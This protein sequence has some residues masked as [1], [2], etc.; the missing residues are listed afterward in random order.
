[1]S[2]YS[3]KLIYDYVKGN[4]IDN[5][6]I[7]ELESDYIF[8]KEVT[9]AS[10]DK[11]MYNLCDDKLK[12]NFEL[13]KFFIMK[14]KNDET[15]VKRVGNEF[16]ALSNNENDIFEINIIVSE[17]VKKDY[18][19]IL[20]NIHLI[21]ANNKYNALR[22]EYGIEIYDEKQEVK[23][24]CQM[25]FEC[26]IN[27]YAGR[28]IIIDYIAKKMVDEIFDEKP[29]EELVHAKF[30]NKEELEK[31]GIINYIINYV[32]FYDSN[33]ADYL[34]TDIKLLEELKNKM[35]KI[36]DNFDNYNEIKEW[37]MMNWIIEYLNECSSEMVIISSIELIRFV[38]R[39]LNI[40]HPI[41]ESELIGYDDYM[42]EYNYS[43]IKS[44][45]QYHRIKNKVKEV[46]QKNEIPDPYIEEQGDGS[47]TKILKFKKEQ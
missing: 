30:K 34:K 33:L 37:E 44:D 2:K 36:K 41:I 43:L 9:D 7:D 27:M 10:N 15:F 24:Y 39:D 40:N 1:M 38:T 8:I 21:S 35:E 19:N 5:Y 11:K 16:C 20:E 23:D 14:F 42:E 6:D 46:I 18:D 47:K 22:F 32:S 26:F 28:K 31:Y 12:S 45:I 25:G 3:K 13:M 29:L 17:L 4:N